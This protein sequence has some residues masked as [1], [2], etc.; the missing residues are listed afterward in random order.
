MIY[1]V[2]VVTG[3]LRIYKEA[4]DANYARTTYVKVPFG[5]S[6]FP[7]E[8]YGCPKGNFDSDGTDVDWAETLGN[9]KFWRMHKDGGH[10]AAW[11]KPNELVED[12]REFFGPGGGAYGV[13][14]K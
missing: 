6:V 3:G 1:W 2:S 10:F 7:K 5:V 12:L 8:L 14:Q 13:T 4:T 9:L 11:E